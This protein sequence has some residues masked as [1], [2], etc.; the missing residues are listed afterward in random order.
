MHP[1]GNFGY[2]P[3]KTLAFEDVKW[4][5]L[6]ILTP[7]SNFPI[8]FWWA[9]THSPCGTE[10]RGRNCLVVTII[11]ETFCRWFHSPSFYAGI[12]NKI[13]SPSSS[14]NLDRLEVCRSPWLFASL[15]LL[16]H[17]HKID[18]SLL[19]TLHASKSYLPRLLNL[20]VNP[21]CYS[22]IF[23]VE[24]LFAECPRSTMLNIGPP[25][26]KWQI[27]MEIKWTTLFLCGL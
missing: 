20:K 27:V 3:R 8:S 12:C 14:N 9:V 22:L 16:W 13:H 11:W 17:C 5:V 2:F 6:S 7:I 15:F 25:L 26:F 10:N 24:G 19:P 4:L 18:K 1:F 23:R 21:K